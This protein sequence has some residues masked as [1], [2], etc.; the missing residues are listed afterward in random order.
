MVTAIDDI[1]LLIKDCVANQRKA[2]EALY[3]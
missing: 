2:Q 1:G 3:R